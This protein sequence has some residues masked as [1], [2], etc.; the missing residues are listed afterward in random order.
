MVPRHE[1]GSVR[2]NVSS[3]GS[4]NPSPTYLPVA[5]TTRGSSRRDG[6][7]PI[8]DGPPL[9]LAH[10]RTQDH[11]VTNA[12]DQ[13]TLEAVEMIVAFGEHEG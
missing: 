2:N 7:Q 4:S 9:L 6:C 8:G 3:R 12:V 1:T 10:P 11:Q 5:R 13:P